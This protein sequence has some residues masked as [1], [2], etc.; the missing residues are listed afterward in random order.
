MR[1]GVPKTHINAIKDMYEGLCTSVK[2][3]CEWTEDFWVRIGISQGS[4]LSSY[5]FSVVMDIVTKELQGE[6]P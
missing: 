1:K 3:M 5:L 2:S 4:A 6:V